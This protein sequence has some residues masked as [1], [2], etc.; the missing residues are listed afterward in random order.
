[1]TILYKKTQGVIIEISKVVQAM[2][3]VNKLTYTA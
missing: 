1:M 2:L 3:A